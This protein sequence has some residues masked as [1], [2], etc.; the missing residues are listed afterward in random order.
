MEQQALEKANS[1]W[2]FIVAF[3]LKPQQSQVLSQDV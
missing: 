3:I 2:L 1:C